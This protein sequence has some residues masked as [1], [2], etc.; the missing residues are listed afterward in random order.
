MWFGFKDKL[1]FASEVFVP[2]KGNKECSRIP[3]LD[4][5]HEK[6]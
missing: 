5:E 3:R 1:W 4:Q 2:H 6:P